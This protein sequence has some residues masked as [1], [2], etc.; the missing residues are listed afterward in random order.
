MSRLNLRI[1]VAVLVI[2]VAPVAF[3]QDQKPSATMT[4]SGGAVAIGVGYTWGNGVLEFQGKK[5]PF[6]VDGLSIVDVG[7]AS[8]QGV[9][10]VFYLK[11]PEQFAGN[12]VA[13]GV[14]VTVAGGGSVLTMQN[15]NGVVI[16]LHTTQQGLKFILSANGVS[17]HMKS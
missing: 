8:I 7:A 12:Y 5:Y 6:S 2:A 17:I 1:A 11:N 14:G 13:A 15:Q 10:D 9:G 16:H 3:A 4:L